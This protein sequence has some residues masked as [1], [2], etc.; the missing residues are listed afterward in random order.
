MGYRESCDQGR[1]GDLGM[2]NQIVGAVDAKVNA[3]GGVDDPDNVVQRSCNII[4]YVELIVGG[5]GIVSAI[6]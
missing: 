4:I 2:E 1:I 5:N 6:C 3:Y